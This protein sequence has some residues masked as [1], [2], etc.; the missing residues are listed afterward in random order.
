MPDFVKPLK[1]EDLLTGG[2]LNPFPYEADPTEDVLWSN[3]VAVE[4]QD[5]TILKSGNDMVFEDL[6]QTTPV[7]LTQLLSG[8][9]GETD[10]DRKFALAMGVL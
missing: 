4:S 1:M 3:G 7:T 9:S 5:L 6:V 2:Q 10:D 8:G